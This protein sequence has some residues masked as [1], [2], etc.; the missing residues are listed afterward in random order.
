[1]KDITQ[2]GGS[3]VLQSNREMKRRKSIEYDGNQLRAAPETG[4]SK[5]FKGFA[6][7]GNT[8]PIVGSTAPTYAT[9]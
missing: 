4:D 8:E 5:T 7:L 1:M 9:Q 6:L 3:S 2:G